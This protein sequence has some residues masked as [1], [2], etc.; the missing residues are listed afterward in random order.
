MRLNKEEDMVKL[1]FSLMV[2]FLA[3]TTVFFVFLTKFNEEAK[4]EALLSKVAGVM[5][6]NLKNRDRS[7]PVPTETIII[8]PTNSPEPTDEPSPTDVPKKILEI[9]LGSMKIIDKTIEVKAVKEAVDS[10]KGFVEPKDGKIP[11]QDFDL[12]LNFPENVKPGSSDNKFIFENKEYEIKV[13]DKKGNVLNSFMFKVDGQN[14]IIN[15]EGGIWSGSA[16]YGVGI[17]SDG[18]KIGEDKFAVE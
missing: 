10:A 8:T 16:E 4:G 7:R 15:P 11:W 5:T 14:V 3:V 13:L 1:L 9:V 6:V 18:N 12:Q 2:F 17:Y